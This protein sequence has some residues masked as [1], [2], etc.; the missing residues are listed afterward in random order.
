MSYVPVSQRKPCATEG[1]TR[2]AIKPKRLCYTCAK[3]NK[4]ASKSKSHDKRVGETYGL[5]PGEYKKI[6]DAQGG[7]CFICHGKGGTKM[8]AVD[9]DHNLTGRE[10]I[11]A[12]LCSSC[13][14][15][16]LGRI[17]HDDPERLEEIL[18]RA[19]IV[20][21]EHPAQDVLKG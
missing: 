10:S 11:R 12:I 20:L 19:L 9:H 17:G 5:L 7:A 18:Q 13:N 16:L 2:Y 3:A 21:R 1:C 6:L 15:I 8:M 14:H 4:K